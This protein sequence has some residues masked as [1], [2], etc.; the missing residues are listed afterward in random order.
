M[1]LADQPRILVQPL[2]APRHETTYIFISGHSFA[3]ISQR[4][5]CGADSNAPAAP[6][7]NT[8]VLPLFTKYCTGC[9]NS[10]D[11]E[12]KLVLESYADLSR[13]GKRGAEVI[14]GHPEQS[15]LLRVLNGQTEPSMP[16]KDNEK[17]KPAD[18]A[19]ACRLDRRRRARAP[20]APRPIRPCLLVPKVA[21]IGPVR[22]PINAVACSPD[23]QWIAVA[24]Y[25][26]VELLSAED[27]RDRA[28]AWRSAGQRERSGIQRR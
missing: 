18:I 10:T 3:G 23:G 16:P 24:R 27:P 15:R 25:G 1:E 5:R 13:G 28:F 7:F 4:R 21:P 6:E 20:A 19:P 8:K 26:V 9:H 14:A 17:P 11:H 2:N 22:R 12:G